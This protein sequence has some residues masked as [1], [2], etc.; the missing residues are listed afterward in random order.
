VNEFDWPT[1]PDRPP[2]KV[3]VFEARPLV[4]EGIAALLDG[5]RGID[6]VGATTHLGEATRMIVEAG[7][8]VVVFGAEVPRHERVRELAA[9]FEAAAASCGRQVGLVC[10]VP[11]GQVT[12]DELNSSDLP[13]VVS[14]GVSVQGLR[15]AIDTVYS[16]GDSAL[17][18]E[19]MRRRIT[20]SIDTASAP[21]AALT[22]RERDVLRGLSAGLSTREIAA[23][24]GITVNT[25]RTH[26][27]HL[28]P[29]LGVHTRLHAAAIAAVERLVDE[30]PRPIQE[31]HRDRV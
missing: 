26:V 22:G 19:V 28:M 8:Q 4:A 1:P 12:A 10:I 15:D 31:A 14:T 29:K 30:S 9:H 2:I 24:L 5:A 11:E 13:T 18:L 3:A 23:Q 17:P 16:G 27:Q 25:V 20:S 7:V 21:A 6:V